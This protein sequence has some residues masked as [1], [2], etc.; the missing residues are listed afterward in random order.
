MDLEPFSKSEHRHAISTRVEHANRIISNVSHW[1]TVNICLQASSASLEKE[2]TA[3]QD[4][5][6]IPTAPV[7]FGG[8]IMCAV[9][10]LAPQG[11]EKG[12]TIIW[13]MIGQSATMYPSRM[14]GAKV[15]ENEPMW[16]T[17][18]SLSSDFSAGEGG[19]RNDISNS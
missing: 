10:T 5:I 12:P 8:A 7:P 14:A 15:F 13:L 16:I 3:A 6:M 2:Y 1:Y 19:F 9:A 4:A 11:A 18:P 17:R